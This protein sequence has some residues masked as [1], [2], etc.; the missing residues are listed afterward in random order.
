MADEPT[1]LASRETGWRPG[2]AYLLAVICLVLGTALGYLFRGSGARPT[3]TAGPAAQAQAPANGAPKMPSLDD[4]KRMADKQAEPLLAKLK[5]DPNNA[6]LLV[7]IARIYEATHQFKEAVSYF[8]K[9]LQA[10]PKNVGTRTEMASCLYYDGDVDGAISQLQLAL[11]DKPTDANSLFNLG[12]I[13]W[14][15]KGDSKGALTAWQQL[16]KSNP[17]LDSK[18]KAQVQKLMAALQE[19]DGGE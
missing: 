1:N 3:R 10:S 11:Q 5:T 14:K 15:G 9:A 19:N 6:D 7:Q 4:M 18:K 17:D 16:L 12:L 2:H 13:R 8:E